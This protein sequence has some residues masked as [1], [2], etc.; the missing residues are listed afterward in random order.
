[1]IQSI[2]PDCL[3][4]TSPPAAGS[5]APVRMDMP[6]D[7]WTLVELFDRATWEAER[8]GNAPRCAPRYWY[9][10]RTML[11][12]QKQVAD[13]AWK[14]WC[15]AKHIPAD[16]WK[17]G[18][19]LALAFTAADDVAELTI[20][21]ACVLARERLGLPRRRTTADARLRRS[22]TAMDKSLEKR[23][24]EFGEVSDPTGLGS[25]VAELRHKLAALDNACAALEARHNV[26]ALPRRAK[27]PK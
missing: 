16:R 25:R 19:L 21:A 24:G 7:G 12:V 5:G 4:D 9:F 10:G 27:Q 17:R 18:R 14:A 11:F 2:V 26:L 20:A 1:M 22:L 6:G 13:G 8:I 15:A 23:L 3:R